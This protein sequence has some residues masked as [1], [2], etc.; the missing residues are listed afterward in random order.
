MLK[1]PGKESTLESHFFMVFFCGFW[2]QEEAVAPCFCHNSK[3]AD[4]SSIPRVWKSNLGLKDTTNLKSQKSG[5]TARLLGI[6]N[7]ACLC[8]DKYTLTLVAGR[9]KYTIWARQKRIPRNSGTFH[10][11]QPGSHR[12]CVSVSP[13]DEWD[14]DTLQRRFYTLH[15]LHSFVV[16]DL[17]Q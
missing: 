9:L 5:Y 11:R 13:H 2:G 7:N 15:S 8:C 10:R 6:S 3:N 1:K 14:C 16:C 12:P 4:W 17:I